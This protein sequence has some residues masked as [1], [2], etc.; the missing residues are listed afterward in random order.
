MSNN[1]TIFR[2]SAVIRLTGGSPFSEMELTELDKRYIEDFLDYIRSRY[3][4]CICLMGGLS[5]DLLEISIYTDDQPI[6]RTGSTTY[7]FTNNEKIGISTD[8]ALEKISA[9]IYGKE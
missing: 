4:S 8:H 3:S 9:F 2:T 7:Q 6:I 5:L 1:L